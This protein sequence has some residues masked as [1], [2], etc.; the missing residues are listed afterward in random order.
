M[1][2]T[3][4]LEKLSLADLQKAF[5]EFVNAILA[6]PTLVGAVDGKAAKQMKDAEGKGY[7]SPSLSRWSNPCFVAYFLFLWSKNF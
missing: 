2:G 5:A 4:V 1:A 7:Q 6:D 3:C